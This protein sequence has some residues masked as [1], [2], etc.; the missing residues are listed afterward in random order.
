MNVLIL[1]LENRL[2]GEHQGIIE[3]SEFY[4]RVTYC[5]ATEIGVVIMH[6]LCSV[7]L[8]ILM[9]FLTGKYALLELFEARR[10]FESHIWD[11][12]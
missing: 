7:F 5:Q 6:C 3:C 12:A 9:I 8:Q 10:K 11:L 2:S 4:G 1:V